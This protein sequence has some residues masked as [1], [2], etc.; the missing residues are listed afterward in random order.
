MGFKYFYVEA[1]APKLSA[2]KNKKTSMFRQYLPSTKKD[3]DENDNDT[4][5]GDGGDGGAG[6]E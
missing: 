2:T 4:S 3:D 5:V 6:G 1:K